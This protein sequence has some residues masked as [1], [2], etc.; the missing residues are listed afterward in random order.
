MNYRID[1]KLYLSVLRINLFEHKKIYLF[2]NESLFDNKNYFQ[3]T[4]YI[5][6]SFFSSIFMIEVHFCSII[7]NILMAFSVTLST[8]ATIKKNSK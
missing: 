6:K 1:I 8:Q 2:F 3:Q 5:F 4:F 7:S